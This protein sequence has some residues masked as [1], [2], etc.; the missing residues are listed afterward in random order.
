[1]ADIKQNDTKDKVFLLSLTEVE[2]YF[3]YHD[4]RLLCEATEYTL[5]QEINVSGAD[6]KGKGNVCNW[7]LRTPG[8]DNARA[9]YIR[10]DCI[11]ASKIS[12]RER[13]FSGVSDV[14]I[15]AHFELGVRPAMWIEI[16]K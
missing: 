3:A 7:W 4:D 14:G 10:P 16:P 12:D 6:F 9:D 11:D 13:K 15:I 8:S 2:E 1:M 5:A